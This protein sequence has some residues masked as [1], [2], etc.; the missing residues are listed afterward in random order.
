MSQGRVTAI[1]NT[2]V[3][4][5]YASLVLDR[6]AR[7]TC[8]LI[9]AE[10]ASIL[11][12]DPT[13]DGGAIAVAARGLGEDLVGSRVDATRGLTGEVLASGEPAL[14]GEARATNGDRLR[15]TRAAAPV[16]WDSEVR[17][18]LAARTSD[19]ARN[20]G[21]RELRLLSQLADTVGA[22]LQHV[23]PRAE[24]LASVRPYVS[25]LMLAIDARD[26][27]TAQHSEA[28]VHLCTSMG[29]CMGLDAPELLELESAALLHDL[30]KIGVPTDVLNRPGALDEAERALVER[31]T[32]WGAQLLAGVPGL[33][34]VATIVRFHHERW[35][36]G[37][38]PEGLR[39]ERIPVASRIVA[40]CDAY[41]AM[42]SDRPYRAALKVD[43]ALTELEEGA[44]SQ[45]DPAVVECF[46]ETIPPRKTAKEA[47]P[48]DLL[49]T[50]TNW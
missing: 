15:R 23:D 13:R 41:H 46:I 43:R 26:R 2:V 45:F 25:S 9:G 10:Q 11:V 21:P 48:S 1:A 33:E 24:F 38:Y 39:G 4:G 18:A 27:Y 35:D 20:F 47:E 7:Q 37:G 29:R 32:V 14:S 19:P 6:L 12:R 31:H 40:V 5:G 8:Q 49:T 22:A 42:T 16:G 34:P 36:G 44:G 28:V 17:G 3:E 30:G 50:R